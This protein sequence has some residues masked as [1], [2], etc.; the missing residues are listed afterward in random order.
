MAKKTKE[1]MV[2]DNDNYPMLASDPTDVLAAF[3]ANF[4]GEDVTRRDVFKEI[5]TATAG[6]DFWMIET[7]D[8][9]TPYEELTG[10][11][12]YV[13]N[14][15]AL[16]EGEFGK[17][18]STI[19]LCTSEDGAFGDGDPG[20]SCVSCDK[21]DF[22]P[23]GE[24]PECGNRKPIY[25][26]IPEINGVLPVCFKITGTSF[27]ALKKFRGFCAQNG[28]QFWD[29]ELKFTLTPGQTKNG[30]KK[31]VVTFE[32]ISNIKKTNPEAHAKILEYRK[33]FLPYMRP[34]S[35]APPAE[36]QKAA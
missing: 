34:D 33:T 14:E 36:A 28:I 4:E 31:S 26:L 27:P 11:I 7:L 13:G 16:F 18:G 32:V 15:R 30:S 10:V 17:G 1:V 12:L 2:L 6:E 19:P 22:G 8:G 5:P 24:V 35:L 3:E 25:A 21:K 9:K 23:D 29:L 20:G